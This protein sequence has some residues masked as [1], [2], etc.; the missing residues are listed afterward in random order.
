MGK[1]AKDNIEGK[2]KDEVEEGCVGGL[3]QEDEVNVK[4]LHPFLLFKSFP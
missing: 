1:N 2:G 4:L 3:K